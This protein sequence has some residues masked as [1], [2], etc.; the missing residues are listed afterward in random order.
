MSQTEVSPTQA[1]GDIIGTSVPRLEGRQK[2]TGQ[3]QFTDDIK[4]PGMLYTALLGSLYAH[5]RIRCAL[6]LRRV[7]FSLAFSSTH[8]GGRNRKKKPIEI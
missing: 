6:F 8:R 4:R 7:L 2:V 5:A 3:A 1:V